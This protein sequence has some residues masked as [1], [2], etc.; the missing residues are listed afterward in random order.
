MTPCVTLHNIYHVRLQ[1][2]MLPGATCRGKRQCRWRCGCL[3][4]K[5]QI[6]LT[7]RSAEGKRKSKHFLPAS[8]DP[9]PIWKISHFPSVPISQLKSISHALST[10]I[11]KIH[12]HKFTTTTSHR[13]G[14]DSIF[15][16]TLKTS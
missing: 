3:T 4:R 12:A 9:F 8:S 5:Q 14:Q 10:L 1:G 16:A 13:A 6:L 2:L 7:Q 15:S 11:S